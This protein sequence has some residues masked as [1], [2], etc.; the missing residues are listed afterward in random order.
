MSLSTLIPWTDLLSHRF[1]DVREEYGPNSH[2]VVSALEA[3]DETR[4]LERVGK[5][6]LENDGAI[7]ATR[8]LGGWCFLRPQLVAATERV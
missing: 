8:V 3:L 4:W 2:A 7:R 6:W 5:P 1:D